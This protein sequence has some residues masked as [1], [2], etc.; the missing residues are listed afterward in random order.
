MKRALPLGIIRRTA[1]CFLVGSLLSVLTGSAFATTGIDPAALVI[2]AELTSVLG[3]PVTKVVPVPEQTDDDT[4]GRLVYCTF[5]G[6]QSAVIVSVVSFSSAK[7]AQAKM[8]KQQAM[9]RLEG[10][11]AQVIEEKGLGDRA[12]W[13]TTDQGAEYI[14]IKGARV[15]GIGLGG[16]LT[17][18]PASYREALRALA[19]GAVAKL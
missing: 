12:Y 1:G 16:K 19:V 10:D 9:E 5:H 17:Q 18:T 15:L 6:G 8:S 14:V 4:G 3:Q 11:N 7:E 13:A 2:K